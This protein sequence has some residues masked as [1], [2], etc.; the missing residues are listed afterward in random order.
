MIETIFGPPGTGKTSELVKIAEEEAEQGS[1]L[2]LSYTRAAAQEATSR[3]ESPR[4]E[5]S[6]LHSVAFRTL[7]MSRSAVVD[8]K[9]LAEFGKTTGLPFKGS[10]RGSDELQEGDEYVNCLAFSHNACIDPM[11]GWDRLGRPGTPTRYG[12][13]VK[14]YDDWKRT[15]GFMDFDDMLA[16][17]CL[18]DPKRMPAPRTL[19][20]DEAQDCSPL[21]WAA[22]TAIQKN[23]VTN[24]FIAGDDDQAIYEWNGSNPHGMIEFHEKYGTDLRVL[25]Q[26]HR[27]PIHAMNMAITKALEPMQRRHPKEFRPRDAEGLITRYGDIM[28]IELSDFHDDGIGALVLTRD[29]FK[30]EEIKRELNR[31]MVPYDV[32]GGLSPWTSKLANAIRRK[33]DVDI[34]IQWRSFYRKA[35]LSQP[36]HLLLSTVHQAKGREHRRVVV[37]LE[38]TGKALRDIHAMPDAE[39][40]ILYVALTRTSDELH[41]CGSNPFI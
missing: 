8:A 19:I 31:L 16:T 5:A 22:F 25:E 20:L 41:L 40:R 34:P 30:Q 2:Y 14:A 1:V 17:F 10:E 12:N 23:G 32:L 9:K 21:Q 26:S 38:L 36:I 18:S 7:G 13:F 35:D 3:I 28:N 39:L 27:V 33:E 37:D 15:F 11:E 4:I 6:T 29:R 24:V